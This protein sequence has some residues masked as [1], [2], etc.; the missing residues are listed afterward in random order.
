MQVGLGTDQLRVNL[1]FQRASYGFTIFSIMSPAIILFGSWAFTIVL[2]IKG[3]IASR[4]A[5]DRFKKR[6][7]EVFFHADR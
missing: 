4:I 6:L 7:R 2:T 5:A 1:S 3:R